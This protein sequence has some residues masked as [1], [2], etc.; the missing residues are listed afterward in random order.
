[1]MILGTSITRSASQSRTCSSPTGQRVRKNRRT[2][3]DCSSICGSTS[4]SSGTVGTGSTICSTVCCRT[5][6]CGLTRCP[7]PHWSS[8][9]AIRRALLVASAWQSSGS[10]ERC[11]SRA[12]HHGCD[13][14]L[15]PGPFAA[16]GMLDRR[17]RLRFAALS[18][19]AVDMTSR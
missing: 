17:S 5:R 19:S 6:T 9:S 8:G 15:L 16:K 4:W 12:Q 13:E 14:G 11:A 2:S 7:W 10:V 3:T 18:R 1:M